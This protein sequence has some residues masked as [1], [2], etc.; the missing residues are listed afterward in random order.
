[1]IG[2]AVRRALVLG[3]TQGIA[4][5]LPISSSAHLTLVPWMLGWPEQRDRTTLAAGLHA[6]SALGIA[7]A[8]RRQL[9]ALTREELTV[10]AA[11]TVPAAITGLL[12][13]DLVEA[14]LGRPRQVAALMAVAGLALAAADRR[15]PAS[16]LGDLGAGTA[17]KIT[18]AGH[19]GY[20]L[21]DLGAK[22]ASKITN[23]RSGDERWRSTSRNP[24]QDHQGTTRDRPPTSRAAA[25]AALAQVAALAPGV[26]RNGATLTALRAAGTDRGPAHEFSLLMSLP[27][28]LGA[29]GLTLARADRETMK[30]LIPSLALG[31]PTA[32]LAAGLTVTHVLPGPWWPITLYRLGLAAIVVA[33]SAGGARR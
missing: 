27:I 13:A 11:T 16:H 2:I 22:P 7:Y 4:E 15:G 18:R 1:M 25:A 12:A 21:G 33:R 17:A 5:V 28:T 14:R 6:G 26:S 23:A 9:A 10:L 31:A 32:A 29:A 19:R 3:L 24:A 30:D 20:P 8:L